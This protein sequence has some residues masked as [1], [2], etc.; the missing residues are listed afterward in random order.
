M[1]NPYSPPAYETKGFASIASNETTERL[2]YA[3]WIAL[4]AI[5]VP[6]PL[7]FAFTITKGWAQLG[8][9]LALIPILAIGYWICGW[10]RKGGKP[11]FIGGTIVAL[12]Q[13]APIL[14]VVIGGTAAS[15]VKPLDRFFGANPPTPTADPTGDIEVHDIGLET[16][17]AGFLTT[18]VTGF[19][20]A[21][22]AAIIGY[23]IRFCTPE[24]WWRA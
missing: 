22:V 5:N 4:V 10:K 24:R 13:F 19:G 2:S 15:L 14:H 1:D 18:L 3:G 23:S 9:G 11:L 17:L 16:L 7:F 21:A 8:I 20:L 12:S 6:L